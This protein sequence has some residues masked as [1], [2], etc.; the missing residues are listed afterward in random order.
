MHHYD[1]R[2]HGR[3][4]GFTC[5]PITWKVSSACMQVISSGSD[6]DTWHSSRHVYETKTCVT[7]FFS[8]PPFLTPLHSLHSSSLLH[9]TWFHYC[10]IF[11][12]QLSFLGRWTGESR[13]VY[14][15]HRTFARHIFLPKVTTIFK[16]KEKKKKS[17][18]LPAPT[19]TSTSC[20][21]C[22]VSVREYSATASR[23]PS[24]PAAF[25]ARRG[26][27]SP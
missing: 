1:V 6:P 10:R 23:F 2:K 20:S 4:A 3:R 27:C 26:S 12:P 13:Q 25:R 14:G 9:N 11:F 19:P 15:K 18:S 7:F 17:P 22:S 16:K 8:R 5:G 24:A 21:F